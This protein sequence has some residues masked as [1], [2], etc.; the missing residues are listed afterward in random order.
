MEH[1]KSE[2]K[3][4]ATETIGFNLYKNF[5]EHIGANYS[6]KVPK[7]NS[8]N[9]KTLTEVKTL[10]SDGLENNL[11]LLSTELE[12]TKTLEWLE[13]EKLRLEGLLSSDDWKAEFQGKII[14]SKLCGEVLKG[15]ALSIREC[16]VDIAITE[17]DDSIKEIAEIFKLM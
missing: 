13:T 1:I 14:F 16:Y 3:R 2:M 10:I 6:I 8:I 9:Q 7:V 4:I 12:K 15:N 11:N 17:N 5:K